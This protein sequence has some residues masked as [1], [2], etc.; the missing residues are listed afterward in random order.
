MLV[1]IEEWLVDRRVGINGSFSR[2]TVVGVQ[3]FTIYIY[4]SGEGT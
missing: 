1:Q 3:L 2:L 4:D